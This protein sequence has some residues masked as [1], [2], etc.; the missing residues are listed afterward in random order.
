MKADMKITVANPQDT[1]EFAAHFVSE[2][3]RM[4]VGR[5]ATVV[6]LSGELG[7]GKTTFT[8]GVA[9]AL[10]LKH[11]VTSPTFVLEKVYR[12]P[13]GKTF[14]KLV[15]I[16]AYRL[17]R[18]KELKTLHFEKLLAD[19]HALILI[20]WPEHVEDALP[21]AAQAISFKV[22]D[23]MTRNIVWQKKTKKR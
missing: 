6:K 2:I 22:I 7:S 13:K 5:R 8:K 12:I 16:D 14:A 20:E 4:G 1:K 10:G 3:S 23:D 21:R 11:T 15:H 18:G 19:P 17:E 9:K